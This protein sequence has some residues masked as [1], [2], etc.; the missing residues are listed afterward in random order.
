MNWKLICLSEILYMNNLKTYVSYRQRFSSSA[1]INSKISKRNSHYR[2][3]D[4]MKKI[5][6]L[7]A[8]VSAA[9]LLLPMASC[10]SGEDDFTAGMT[11]EEKA[12]WEA[13][14]NDPYGKYP[15]LVTYTTGYNLTNQGSDVL[16]GTAYEDD[17]TENNA[18]TRYLKEVLNV[19]NEN[20]FE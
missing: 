11:E 19:Q 14:A 7:L 5:V 6:K 13:A 3:N 2:R 12:A 18:Y 10:S 20:A 16:A 17:T 4:E 9:A 8:L 1:E 15:E